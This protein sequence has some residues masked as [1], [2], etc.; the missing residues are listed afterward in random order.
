MSANPSPSLYVVSPDGRLKVDPEPVTDIMIISTELELCYALTEAVQFQTWSRSVIPGGQP[1]PP[2]G[3]KAWFKTGNL[4]LDPKEDA[5]FWIGKDT[6]FIRYRN[7][8]SNGDVELWDRTE[9]YL[10][11]AMFASVGLML[12]AGVFAFGKGFVT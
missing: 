3:A 6:L 8:A 2:Y 7:E 10:K 12:L 9:K 11:Y 4:E 5:G 1:D